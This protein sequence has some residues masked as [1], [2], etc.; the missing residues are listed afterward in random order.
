MWARGSFAVKGYFDTR[1]PGQSYFGAEPVRWPSTPTAAGSMWPTWAR[2][3]VAVIDTRKL[4]PKASR[5][6]AWS[7]PTASFPRNGCRSRWRSSPR[8]PAAS[9]TSPPTRAREPGRTTFRSE[10]GGVATSRAATRSSTYIATLLYGSLATLD[11]REIAS[12]L[13]AWT[14][15]VLA[16]NR[17]KAAQEKIAF[18]G[19]AQ[20]RIRH[21]I[22][23][24]KENRTYDQILGD[25]EQDGKPVGNGDAQPGHVRPG[26]HAQPAQA[27]AAIRRARQ[28]LR[29]RRGLR[30]RPRLVERRHRH[31]LSRKDLAAELSRRAA[32]LRLRGRGG[33]RLSAAAKD[34]RRERAGQR[35]SV[36]QSGRA[37]Q[38]LLPLRR[39]HL[40]HVLR[41]ERGRRS[42]AGADAGRA[43]TARTRR[44]RRAKRCPPS[45]AAA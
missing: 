20:D 23:I 13:P 35:L 18:A 24:I 22:Y 37:R 30:R 44:S 19:G 33:R 16:S 12:N 4:T 28:L 15:T 21:V 17:M 1:L 8:P 45:G 5:R 11:E 36:G 25:L 3:A 14:A 9:C 26:H 31:G 41:R 29:L 34:S 2:D 27:G 6:P 7:S 10:D 38:D 40:V 43:R 42:H 39:V 32:H